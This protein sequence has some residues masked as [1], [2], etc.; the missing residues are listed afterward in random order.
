[1]LAWRTVASLE[2]V[3]LD[4]LAARKEHY[5]RI[6]VVDAR[7]FVWIRAESPDRSWLEPRRQNPD[8]VL[9]RGGRRIAYHAVFF[10]DAPEDARYQVDALFREKYGAVDLLRSLV[11]R[12]PTIPIRLDPR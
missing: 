1:L 6:W 11:R 5:A 7:P 2:V 12:T 4:I 10:D 8:V 3:T 9:W